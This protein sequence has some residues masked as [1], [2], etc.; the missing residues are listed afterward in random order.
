MIA[1]ITTKPEG[2]I[3]M[4][5]KYHSKWSDTEIFLSGPNWW[6]NLPVDTAMQPQGMVTA[7]IIVTSLPGS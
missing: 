3:I 4:W 6:I 7:Y 2:K 5:I 1:V